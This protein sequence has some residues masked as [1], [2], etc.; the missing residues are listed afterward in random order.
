MLGVAKLFAY[1]QSAINDFHSE[2]P[3]EKFNTMH[4][5]NKMLLVYY[6]MAKSTMMDQLAHALYVFFNVFNMFVTVST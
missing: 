2:E 4:Y 6:N 1:C 5:T 3:R